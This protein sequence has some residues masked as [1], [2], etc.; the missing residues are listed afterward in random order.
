M[1]KKMLWLILD[2][3]FLVFFNAFFFL[4]GGVDHNAS[5]WISYLF[6]HFAYLMLLLT[7]YFIKKGESAVIFGFALYSV[8][9][10]YFILEAT[11]G[12]LFILSSPESY[13]VTLLSQGLIAGLYIVLLISNM[14]ANERTAEKEEK[15]QVE[16]SYVKKTASELSS[17][18]S[19]ID[20]AGLRKK[21]EKVFDALKSS[22]A[23]SHPDVAGIENDILISIREIKDA[24][25]TEDE[26]FITNKI[27][28][29]LRLISERNSRL[30]LLN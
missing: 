6:I 14:L 22:P 13:K 5:V 3:V 21:V 8:S 11:I 15:R 28:T 12:I 24:L 27:N 25:Q 19:D 1:K 4:L 30:K 17:I 7:P 26:S 20:D 23:R 9:A 16:I 29:L 10:Y 2:S 18:M